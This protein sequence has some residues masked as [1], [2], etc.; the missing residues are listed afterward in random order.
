MT[1]LSAA[2]TD[3]FQVTLDGPSLASY[4]AFKLYFQS[5]RTS[6]GPTTLTL[7]YSLNGGAFITTA[8]TAVPGNPG[9][10]E[11]AVDLSG[12]TMLNA[13]TSL[14]FRLAVSGSTGGNARV[15]N[16]QVQAV[17]TVDPLINGISPATIEAGSADFSLAVTGSNFKPGSVVS[18]NSQNLMTTYKSSTSLVAVVP[19]AAVALDGSYPVVVTNPSAVP[20]PAA[21]FSVTPALVHWTGTAGNT[22]WF[23]PTNWST[24]ALPATTDEVVLDHRYVAGSFTVSLDQ[25]VAVSIKSLTINPGVGDSIF[26]L[27]PASNTLATALTLS[28]SGSGVVALAIYNKG[29]VTNASGASSGSGIDVLGTGA[30][31][32]IYNGGSYRQATVRGHAAVVENLSAVAGTELGIFD[33]R[34][35]TNGT[36]SYSLSL[37]GRTYGTLIFRNRLGQA[38][39]SYPGSVNSLIVQ[40]NLIIGPGAVLIATLNTTNEARF[41]GDVRAQGTLQFKN[42]SAGSPSQVL[43][44]GSK[45]Q[46]I[47]GNVT[48]EPGVGMMLN[49]PS[50]V[51]LAT[52]LLQNG[53][54]TLTSGP[55]TTTATNLLTLGT[56]ASIAGGSSA[57]YVNGPLARQT[58][59]GALS[60][61]VFPLGSGGVYRPVV[62]NATA[63][64]ATTYLVA[65]AQGPAP[66][67]NNLPTST[68]GL[69][70]LTRVSRAWSYTITPTPAA[71]NF[72]GNVLLPYELTDQVNAPND[73]SFV[74]G[75]NSGSGWQNI[76]KSAV[77]VTTAAP[78]GGYAS[79]TITSGTFT[80]FSTFSLASTSAD[81]AIN[82]LPVILTSFAA[83]RQ[84]AN[85]RLSWATASELRNAHFEV[86]RSLDGQVFTAVATVGGQGTTALA[87]QYTALDAA[88]P[89]AVLYYRLAQV[90]IDGRTTYSPLVVLTATSSAVLYPNPARDRLVV[91]APAG[92]QVRVLDLA[93]RVLQT[94][95][96]PLS[97]EVSVASLPAG[98]YLLQLSEGAQ[99]LRFSKE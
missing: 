10:N 92:T 47:S 56:T 44:S 41:L 15:D 42:G 94:V 88:A 62:L 64:D 83:R 68:T 29:V 69:P 48:F 63:Q 24:G 80:S 82:P 73:A 33:F 67:Y 4:S 97:G 60:G 19:A 2:S 86:Q 93:G 22:S 45:S 66:D 35:P 65:L 70:Q 95:A 76:G 9:F 40:G 77:S 38:S 20:S 7:Q 53:M 46:I 81:A 8:N 79:G 34:L 11:A 54:F 59:A 43:F 71:N 61:L 91:P 72:S 31:A 6:T 51:V 1:A 37:A 32:F 57:S 58:A 14:K 98:T 18:F 28:N 5:F 89:N 49:N 3:Y 84:A 74:I 30:T 23:E 99:P 21:T 52:P 50:G 78:A 25:N 39:T 87:R 27:V 13:P 75:K 85:V 16:F 36:A 90:D 17:N 26:A 12:L 96:L 55:L